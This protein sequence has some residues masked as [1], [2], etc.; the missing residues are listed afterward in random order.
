MKSRLLGPAL[1]T[2]AI[3]ATTL[4][5][6][7]VEAPSAAAAAKP[8]CHSAIINVPAKETVKIRTSPRTSAT[9]IGVWGKGKKGALCSDGKSFKG[10]S[11]KACGKKSNLWLYGGPNSSSKEGYVPRTCIKW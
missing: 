1:A 11:Y 9:A 3:A 10:G 6:A 7:A 4:G 5:V 2:A 8:N